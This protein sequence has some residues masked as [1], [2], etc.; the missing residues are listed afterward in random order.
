[1]DSSLDYIIPDPEIDDLPEDGYGVNFHDI[2]KDDMNNGDGLRVV[3]WLSGCGHRCPG[4]QNPETWSKCSGI[5]FTIESESELFEAL[6]KPWIDGITFSGGD[7]L[8]PANRNFVGAMI[9]KIRN[10]FPEKDVWLYTGYTLKSDKNGWYFEDE[11]PW[12]LEHDRFSLGY[13]DQIDVLVDGPFDKEIRAVDL[14][15]KKDPHW[16]GSSNQR[17][18]DVKKTIVA[19]AIVFH[20]D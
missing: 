4:C 12:L 10:D 8:F 13:L 1:M 7:P 19:D 15:E 5:P 18:I 3:L 17:V 6:D 11:C 9:E 20:K 14:A 16:C 2:T